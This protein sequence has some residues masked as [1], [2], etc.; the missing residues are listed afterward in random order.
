MKKLVLFVALALFMATGFSQPWL[1]L[2]PKYKRSNPSFFDEKKA[3]EKYWSQYQIK[4]GFYVDENGEKKKAYGFKQFKRW[5]WFMEPRVDNNGYLPVKT[6]AEELQKLQKNKSS[7]GNWQSLGP[8]ITPTEIGS[9]D[10]DGIG[11]INQISFDPNNANIFYVAAPDGGVWKTTDGGNTWQPITDDF[12]SLGVSDIAISPQNPD[13][14][15]IATGD[16]DGRSA[17][18][19]GVYKSTDGGQSWAVTSL[20]YS[21]ADN[22]KLSRILVDPQNYNKVIVGGSNGIFITTDGGN[23][24]TNV[25][26]NYIKDMAFV[27]GNANIIYATTYSPYDGIAKILKS[28]DG[29]MNFSDISPNISGVARIA[30]GVTPDDPNIVYALMANSDDYGFHSF[31]K[32][33]NQG[34]TWMLMQDASS[35]PNYLDWYDGTGSG[36]QGW[37]DLSIAVDPSDKNHLF[38]G[39]INIWESTN[40]GNSFSQNSLWYH[41]GSSPYVH[42]DQHHLA[43]NPLNGVLYSANDGGVYKYENDTWTNISDGLVISQIYRLGTSQTNNDL[44]IMGLQDNGTILKN[45]SNF[46][47]VLGGDGM[48]AAINPN[49]N[50]I[51]YGEYYYGNIYKST[52][53]GNSFYEISPST[54]G[55]WVTPYVLDPSNPN[56]M[57]IGYTEMYKSTDGGENWSQITNGE[58]NGSKIN[59]IAVAPSNSSYI[60]FSSGTDLYGTTNGGSSW[61]LLYSFTKPITD[62]AVAYND[63]N[64]VFVTLSGFTEDNKV[65]Y[66]L[67]GGNTWTNISSGLPNVPANAIVYQTGTSDLIYVG[68]DLGVFVR[69]G[70]SANWQTFNNGM[71]FVVVDELEINYTTNKIYAATF[72]RGLWMSDLYSDT[73]TSL[74]AEFSSYVANNC[75][76]EVQFF[77]NSSGSPTSWHWDFGDGNT[78]TEQ[79]PVHNYSSTGDY[80]VTLT[81]SNNTDTSSISHTVSIVQSQVTADF[82]SQNNV[83][84]SAPLSV[85]FNNLSANASSY[86]WD[87]GDGS[88][89]TEENPTHTYNN[90][91][92][93]DVKLVASSEVCGT[94]SIIKESFVEIT[95]TSVV[96]AIFPTS[97]TDVYHCCRGMLYDNGYTGQYSNDIT[98]YVVINVPNANYIDLHFYFIDLELNYDSLFIYQGSSTTGQLVGTY[99]GNS[100]P[101]GTGDLQVQGET[102]TIKF[103]SDQYVTGEGF[104][105]SWTCDNH[106]QSINE[107][108]FVK[109]VVFPNP[110]NG[111]VVIHYE[112]IPYNLK[113]STI[114]GKQIKNYKAITNSDFHIKDLKKGVYLINITNQSNT[115]QTKIVIL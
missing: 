4:N 74:N 98:S 106:T 76:G 9:Q 66:S 33:T 88:T 84:C 50:N 44:V 10:I 89:S 73:S 23:S 71:P 65:Y 29:G 40:G 26:P 57:Y 8:T 20:I 27:P 99:T 70:L 56:V 49:N 5:E 95:D 82:T 12:A 102:V 97:G 64:K 38:I 11:R 63:E 55:A 31:Y 101:N 43:F 113:I 91:G 36:G 35:S 14:I 45:N 19:I 92:V 21:L 72:G 69:N 18:S 75:A 24:W 39:G 58:T 48:E 15:Y 109:P 2:I 67:D 53:G 110:S 111:D 6:Y 17:Y 54:D 47:N 105:M 96:T 90:P 3:F 59:D 46:S 32:S 77:D 114:D 42:A 103:K 61:Q 1:K 85:E 107:T 52:N 13:I 78:S 86:I 34:D 94:D 93:Y 41:G 22:V 28:T 79:N 16:R 108:D 7:N 100:L 112:N 25:D 104:K 87:F 68:T 115:V 62:I 37:Y 30:I 80:N 60:Y 51:M 81:V 83:N